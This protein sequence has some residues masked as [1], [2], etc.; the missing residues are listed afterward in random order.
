LAGGDHRGRLAAGI[1]GRKPGAE[2]Y[3]SDFYPGKS[4]DAVTDLIRKYTELK[5]EAKGE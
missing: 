5:H 2:K 3:C 4:G 1:R